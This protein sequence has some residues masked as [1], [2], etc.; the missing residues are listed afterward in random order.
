MKF[1]WTM[2]ALSAV[3]IGGVSLVTLTSTCSAE[4]CH[5]L[6]CYHN[7]MKNVQQDCAV[8]RVPGSPPPPGVPTCP[9]IW[10]KSCVSDCKLPYLC[11][12]WT[13]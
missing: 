4:Q 10:S 12:P 2:I 8:S 5:G 3:F 13:N 6:D 1:K 11:L 9:E 7:C